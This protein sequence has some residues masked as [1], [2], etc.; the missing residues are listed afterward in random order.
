MAFSSKANGPYRPSAEIN[1]TPLIDVMLVLLIVFMV[2]APLLSAGVKVSLPQAQAARPVDPKEPAVVTVA[3]DGSLSIGPDAIAAEGLVPA[4]LA[5]IGN[6]LSRSV[7]LRGDKDAA[8]GDVIRVMDL[9]ASNGITHIAIIT[10]KAAGEGGA[11]PGRSAE[12][13]RAGP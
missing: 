2:T 10:V 1:V 12:A 6:D 9:L 11:A 5:A 8:Y 3:R 13:G 4:V 7:H